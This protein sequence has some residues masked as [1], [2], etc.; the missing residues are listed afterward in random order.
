MRNQGIET[1]TALG[2]VDAG[3]SIGI[4]CIC[5]QPV[6]G[7]RRHRDQAAIAENISGERNRFR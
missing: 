6:D 1:G 4:G 7:L 2:L 3:N 5:C